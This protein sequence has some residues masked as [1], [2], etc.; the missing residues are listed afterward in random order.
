MKRVAICALSG[1]LLIKP[2]NASIA[3]VSG[4][5]FWLHVALSTHKQGY[6]LKMDSKIR[7]YIC[8]T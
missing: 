3:A 2:Q 8:K 1:S 6:D 4:H 7:P 5:W